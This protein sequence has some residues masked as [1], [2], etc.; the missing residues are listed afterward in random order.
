MHVE[1]KSAIKYFTF[2]EL[3]GECLSSGSPS[4]LQRGN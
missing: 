1:K 4:L 2:S 3:L